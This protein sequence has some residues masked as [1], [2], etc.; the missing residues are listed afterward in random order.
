MISRFM[1]GQSAL[2]VT[3]SPSQT[4]SFMLVSLLI[5]L[6]LR[7]LPLSFP[8]LRPFC[9]LRVVNPRPPLANFRLKRRLQR[10]QQAK[11]CHFQLTSWR[12]LLP[13][14]LFLP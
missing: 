8:W 3:L 11:P 9:R 10:H 12:V 1:S 5:H 14:P 2:K 6:F 13:P 7:L 4:H